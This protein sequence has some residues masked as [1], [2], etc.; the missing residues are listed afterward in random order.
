MLLSLRGLS[1]SSLNDDEAALQDYEEA[2]KLNSLH[3]ATF[4]RRGVSLM[5][6]NRY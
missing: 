3:T 2:L 4:I 6:L 1:K 5:K